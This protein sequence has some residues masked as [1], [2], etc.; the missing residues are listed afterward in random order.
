[1]T[2]VCLPLFLRRQIK[3]TALNSVPQTKEALYEALINSAKDLRLIYNV[4]QVD[5]FDRV[6]HAFT[7]ASK[8]LPPVNVLY[9]GTYG[10]FDFSTE[11]KDFVKANTVSQGDEYNASIEEDGPPRERFVKYII[12]FGESVCKKF[13]LLFAILINYELYKDHL[14]LLSQY[15]KLRTEL[16]IILCNKKSIEECISMQQFGLKKSIDVFAFCNQRSVEYFEVYT[17]EALENALE[18]LLQELLGN[19]TTRNEVL[20]DMKKLSLTPE[21]ALEYGACY[22][23]TSFCKNVYPNI[24]IWKR[25]ESFNKE[26]IRFL[27]HK[28]SL[29]NVTDVCEYVTDLMT[30]SP[31]A[32]E[33]IQKLENVIYMKLGLLCASGEYC[34]LKI[35][36]V[37]ALL[38]YDIHDYD[39][40]ETVIVA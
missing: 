39:G 1:M 38:E 32:S 23:T 26:H 3:K 6:R 2:N 29:L 17:Q 8:D 25:Q 12:P 13:P 19:K 20:E 37:P 34:K 30:N 27:M 18:F 4:S 36:Q 10:G 31:I 35:T 33:D 15:S 5:M 28:M 9:N 22:Q 24:S 16:I 7:E 21:L 14:N 11:F 40:Q